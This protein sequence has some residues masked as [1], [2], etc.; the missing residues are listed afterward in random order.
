[1]K[2]ILF[3]GS[4]ILNMPHAAGI[5]VRSIFDGIDPE[6]VLGLEWGEKNEKGKMS[7]IKTYRLEY[8]YMSLA[9]IIDN[10]FFKSTSH[11][12]KKLEIPNNSASSKTEKKKTSQ[13]LLQN[14]R[15]WI[16]L[17][18]SRSRVMIRKRELNK[19][20]EFSP[21]VIYTVGETITN[22]DLSYR[23]SILLNIPIVIHFMDN[24]KHS[25]EWS[26]NPLLKKYQK[27]LTQYCNMCY[28]R[29]SEC[30]AIG[31]RMAETY[32]NETGI[33]HGVIMNSIDTQAFFCPPQND[34]DVIRFT[35]A[36]GLHLGR[37]IALYTIGECIESLNMKADKELRFDIYT[38]NDNIYLYKEKFAN[39]KQTHLIPAVSHDYITQIYQNS[40]VLVHVE[41]DDLKSNEFFKYSVSTKIS[42]YLATG[43]TILFYGPKDIYLYIFLSK[44][45]LAYT[46]SNTDEIKSTILSIIY[47]KDNIY[48]SN[49]VQYAENHFD[50]KVAYNRF[51]DII[52]HA[53]LPE[54]NRV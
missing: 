25:I 43:K 45:H 31:E 54:H 49:A 5:T 2:K 29:S 47:K 17:A 6:Y 41:S 4:R 39:L 8:K 42:E 15:Q 22:L 37:D 52:E 27:K 18:P 46:V 32:E 38:T 23:L 20:K 10:P 34:K 44:N 13:T 14:L 3:V 51:V 30:I 7:S 16:A 33:K 24:W 36:G 48:S 9:R 50:K 12:I 1:M 19:I 26:D 28:S 40:D 11:K 53:S 35:Y 21:Q